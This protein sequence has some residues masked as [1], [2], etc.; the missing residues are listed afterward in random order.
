MKNDILENSDAWLLL[1]I[2]YVYS[3]GN[4]PSEM[5]RIIGCCD[6][7]E[8]AIITLD[9]IKGGLCRLIEKKNIKDLGNLLFLP[10][11]EIISKFNDFKN[12][13]SRKNI[14]DDLNYISKLINAKEWETN[15]DYIKAN[16]KYSFNSL[17]LEKYNELVENYIKGG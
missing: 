1:S 4:K 5:G 10:S 12:S 3:D 9:E 16:E 13:K 6:F 2:I 11:D 15:Y 14:R 17:T 8:H 7:I